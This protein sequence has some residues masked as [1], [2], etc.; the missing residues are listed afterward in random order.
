MSQC[1]WQDFSS[2][3]STALFTSIIVLVVRAAAVLVVVAVVIFF[4]ICSCACFYRRF[5]SRR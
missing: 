2:K 1:L 3:D 5:G 4:F